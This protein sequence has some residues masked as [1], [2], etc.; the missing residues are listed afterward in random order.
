MLEPIVALFVEFGKDDFE[1]S[2]ERLWCFA[3]GTG[4][5]EATEDRLEA[6]EDLLLALKRLIRF[7]L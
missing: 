5:S 4:L 2:R 6:T 7:G 1:E 3:G